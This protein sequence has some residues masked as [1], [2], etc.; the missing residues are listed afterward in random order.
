VEDK[1][2]EDAVG[3]IRREAKNIIN[4]NITMTVAKQP[5]F[6]TEAEIMGSAMMQKPQIP[7]QP[8]PNHTPSQPINCENWVKHTADFAAQQA[9][10]Q[11]AGLNPYASTSSM[12]ETS[13][14]TLASSL[15]ESDQWTQYGF[16]AGGPLTLYTDMLTVVRYMNQ[17]GSGLDVRDRQ[18]L[19]MHI[20]RA[21]IG[22]DLVDW[23]HSRVQ[24]LD[25]RRDARRYGASLLKAGFIRHTTDKAGFSEQCYYTFT[26]P[27]QQQQAQAALLKNADGNLP[28]N[29]NH[30]AYGATHLAADA[31][32]LR[33]ETSSMVSGSTI[34]DYPQQKLP[35]GVS[36]SI[37]HQAGWQ[38]APSVAQHLQNQKMQG[39]MQNSQQNLQMSQQELRAQQMAQ[40]QQL[41]HHDSDTQSIISMSSSISQQHLKLAAHRME[42]RQKKKLSKS[43]QSVGYKTQSGSGSSNSSASKNALQNKSHPENQSIRTSNSDGNNRS[44]SG[45]MNDI[46][47]PDNISE[48]STITSKKLLPAGKPLGYQPAEITASR[49]SFQYA[50]ANPMLPPST[51]TPS[52]F[53][54]ASSS[55]NNSYRPHPQKYQVKQTHSNTTTAS[56]LDSVPKTDNYGQIMQM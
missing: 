5:L 19:K 37:A 52:Q 33:S 45:M 56:T 55:F 38:P 42:K 7:G 39:N 9:H 21:C 10:N 40:M 41:W 4:G 24:G 6:P 47:I 1:S 51:P 35:P 11:I 34:T 17:R 22:S 3:I 28:P 44:N 31:Q 18:W 15:P 30:L 54:Q 8:N 23:L 14:D 29:L 12:T 2:T 46:M 36:P 20:P 50:M 49:L 32:S 53:S 26:D 16:Y 25:D 43:A 27:V 13:S 48:A